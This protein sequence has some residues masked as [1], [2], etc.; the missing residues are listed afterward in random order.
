MR[1]YFILLS[2]VFLATTVFGSG[3]EPEVYQNWRSQ[4]NE[5]FTKGEENF[6]KVKELLLEKYYDSSLTE[7][8]LYQAATDGMLKALNDD[9]KEPWNKLITPTELKELEIDMKG[10]VTG[11]GVKIKFDA[12]AGMATVIG[13]VPGSVGEKDGVKIGDKIVS[14]NG[15]T[16]Q[17]KQLRDM[18]YDIRGSV[19]E[20][21]K[22]KMLR[23]DSLITKDLV[24]EKMSWKAVEATN[25]DL[26]SS[27]PGKKMGYIAIHYFNETTPGL[28]RDALSKQTSLGIQD[29]VIDLRGNEGG[30]FDQAV[31]STELFL[32]KGAVVVR[33]NSRGG[34]TESVKSDR[35]PMIRDIPIVLLVDGNTSSSAELFTGS[36]VDNLKVKVVGERTKGKWNVQSI[37]TLDNQFAIKYTVK[38]FK[39]P[40][41]YSYQ[42]VGLT[43]DIQVTSSLD[44]LEEID[45]SKNP[46]KR[47]EADAALR[48]ACNLF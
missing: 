36:L 17:G 42:D 10:E 45:I 35:D 43:P 40:N 4:P 15:Q 5:R 2:A 8:Q 20:K 7:E 21:V 48:A 39:T 9:G 13:L 12:E 41:N 26:N 16:Y 47:I 34:K 27:L 18:V 37:E 25:F 3:T 19:G 1:F 6:K 33:E 32:P 24:R 44:K 28:L 23:G 38:L 22:L 46:R 30:L 31:Q 14:V 11:V 29:L